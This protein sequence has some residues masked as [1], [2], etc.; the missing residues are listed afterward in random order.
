MLARGGR[1]F[2]S[3][4]PP[5]GCHQQLEAESAFIAPWTASIRPASPNVYTRA[6][7]KCGVPVSN[8]FYSRRPLCIFAVDCACRPITH[9][10]QGDRQRSRRP[11]QLGSRELVGLLSP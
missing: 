7:L 5:A 3:A 10:K 6:T 4:I 8:D 11:A 1:F 2:T 9:A